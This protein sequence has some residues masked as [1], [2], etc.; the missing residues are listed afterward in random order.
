MTDAPPEFGRRA[1]ASYLREL[2]LRPGR[3]RRTWEQ[4]A[5]RVRPG[6][7]NHLAVAEAIAQHL[8]QHPRAGGTSDVVAHQLK[9]TVSRA[10]SGRL[11]SRSA[12]SQFIEVFGF[13]GQEQERL[14]RLWAG[15]RAI[16]VLAGESALPSATFDA[17]AKVMGPWRHQTLS[18]HD[19][20]YVTMDGRLGSTRSL[21][22][23]EATAD[24]VAHLPYLYDTNTTTLETGQGCGELS[25][26]L[27]RISEG[28]YGIDI[29]LS[30]S[31]ALGETHT[32]E[33]W[34]SYHYPG[35]LS[36]PQECQFRRAAMRRL[37]NFDLRVEFHPA[38][39]PEAVWWAVW[40]GVDGPIIEQDEVALDSQ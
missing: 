19:H 5:M 13:T 11:L 21:Q 10:L 35:N 33:Y 2:L 26:S 20:V 25:G 3:Y 7:V 9:D 15:S 1:A 31:L 18:M 6:V 40:D 38:S 29:P 37:E 17:V 27:Y 36:D 30:R 23:I 4:H 8:W 34:T 28:V 22:V 24:G 32:L 14:W 16:S 12:L 39:L